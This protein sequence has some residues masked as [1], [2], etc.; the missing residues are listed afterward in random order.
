MNVASKM[1]TPTK[2]DM[3]NAD[4]WLKE[5][6]YNLSKKEYHRVKRLCNQVIR[7]LRRKETETLNGTMAKGLE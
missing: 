4:K 5:A 3:E 1:R 7:A 2:S 6:Q